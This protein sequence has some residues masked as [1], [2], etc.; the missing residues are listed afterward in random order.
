MRYRVGRKGNR[1]SEGLKGE[2]SVP[3][4]LNLYKADAAPVI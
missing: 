2:V 4:V 1:A 3:K